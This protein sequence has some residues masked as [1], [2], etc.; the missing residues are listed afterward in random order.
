MEEGQYRCPQARSCD[1]VDCDHMA[2]HLPRLGCGHDKCN[3]VDA[4]IVVEGCRCIR[5]PAIQL[6]NKILNKKEELQ[7]GKG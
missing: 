4:T 2:D 5:V 3:Q 6:A 7:S 1:M